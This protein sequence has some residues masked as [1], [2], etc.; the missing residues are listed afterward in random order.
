MTGYETLVSALE[1]RFD[2]HSARVVAREA[3]SDAGLAD[4][5]DWDPGDFERALARVPLA[6]R[7]VGPVKLRLGIAPDEPASA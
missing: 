5:E 1:A 4:R 7:D 6:D 3:A 2:F